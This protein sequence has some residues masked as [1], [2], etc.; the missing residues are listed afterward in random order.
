MSVNE[1]TET[2]KKLLHILQTTDEDAKTLSGGGMTDLMNT[3][4]CLLQ[5]NF[6]QEQIQSFVNKDGIIPSYLQPTER[7]QGNFT[8]ALLAHILTPAQTRAFNASQVL[9]LSTL[10]KPQIDAISDISVGHIYGKIMT[11]SQFSK[12]SNG[13][14]VELNFQQLQAIE[15]LIRSGGVYETSFS[16]EV[17]SHLRNLGRFT[18]AP[19]TRLLS[20]SNLKGGD[21]QFSEI[22]E[23]ISNIEATIDKMNDVK[24]T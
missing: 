13:E 6:S 24:R 11:P 12:I 10:S 20:S 23:L 21:D 19:L 18:H 2:M 22:Q 7:Q 3:H 15:P 8:G 14:D 17:T 4:L 1:R 9:D 16:P 5:D